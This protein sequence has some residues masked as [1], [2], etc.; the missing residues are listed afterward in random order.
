MIKP[1]PCILFLMLCLSPLSY[2]AYAYDVPSPASMTEIEELYHEDQ[3]VRGNDEKLKTSITRTDLD[4]R[5]RVLF[6]LA[7]DQI[8]SAEEKFYAARIV[9]HTELG[10]CGHP[11]MSGPIEPRCSHSPENY[12]LA[13]E[14]AKTAIERGYDAA[15]NLVARSYDR[16]LYYTIG[17]QKYGTLVIWSEAANGFILP[18][19]DR[20]TSD[21]ERARLGQKPLAEKLA[22][23]PEQPALQK[24]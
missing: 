7:S 17:Y 9:H 13:H 1:S 21:V 18:Y 4:R 2:S 23:Y 15:Q 11:F 5:E 12:L 14:L 6:L 22:K 3:V 8:L 10:E 24:N 19:I 16:Y 20:N